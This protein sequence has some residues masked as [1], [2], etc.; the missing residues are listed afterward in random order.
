MAGRGALIDLLRPRA[1]RWLAQREQSEAELLRKL[2]RLAA[3]AAEALD[4]PEMPAD[5]QAVI[6]ELI[7]WLR[8]RHYLSDQRFIESRLRSRQTR[9]GAQ[10]IQ[11]ELSQHGLSLGEA[12]RQHLAQTEL[13]R[14]HAVWARKFGSELPT[15]AAAR[16]TQGRFLMQRGFTG[17]VIRRVLKGEG[18]QASE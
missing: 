15:D 17:E 11:Q 16:A 3:T 6:D 8:E 1:L 12:E 13:Q 18:A 10:R 5:A 4:E 9:F 2:Q 14:A 7:T